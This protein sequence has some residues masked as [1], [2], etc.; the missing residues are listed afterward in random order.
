MGKLDYQFRELREKVS[1]LSDLSL[2]SMKFQQLHMPVVVYNQ[3]AEVL[4][5]CLH[6]AGFN[7]FVDIQKSLT[8][9]FIMKRSRNADM[10]RDE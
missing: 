1:D 2:Q 10:Q 5:K 9:T 8:E 6:G 3:M 4:N 7:S